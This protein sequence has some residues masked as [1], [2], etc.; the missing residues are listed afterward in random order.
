MPALEN[1]EDNAHDYP[2]TSLSAIVRKD[3]DGPHPQLTELFLFVYPLYNMGMYLK[4]YNMEDAK[5]LHLPSTC[6]HFN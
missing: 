5:P 3:V 4:Q 2:Q 6:H 1:T